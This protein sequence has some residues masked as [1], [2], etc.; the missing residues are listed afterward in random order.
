MGRITE[1]QTF[2]EV[3]FDTIDERLFWAGDDEIYLRDCV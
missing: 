3:G 1:V 2:S